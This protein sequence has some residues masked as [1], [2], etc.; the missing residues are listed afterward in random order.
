MFRGK[1]DA[2]GGPILPYTEG[3]DAEAYKSEPESLEAAQKL[4]DDDEWTLGDDGV[5][6]KKSGK[7]T[8]RL[9]FEMIVPQIQFLL[10]T[11]SIIKEQWAK[12]G[13]KL[14]LIPVNAAEVGE[15]YIKTRNYQMLLFG[16]ILK[17]NPDVFAFWHSSEKFYPGLNLSLYENR[18]VDA[19]LESIRKDFDPESRKVSLSKLQSLILDDH[20][21]I[22]LF[23][24]HYLYVT[25]GKLRGFD[26]KTLTT[27]SDRFQNVSQWYLKT[28]RIWKK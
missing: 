16:N 21:A 8:A 28:K 2:I 11:A 17:N 5:R 9:E 23:S 27:P 18:K 4:L 25:N 7:L 20:P 6:A 13:I 1:A 14:T 3:Y 12:A 19:L 10:E 24:P 26:V 22:F 15:Q